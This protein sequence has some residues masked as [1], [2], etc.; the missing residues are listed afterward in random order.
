M[1]EPSLHFFAPRPLKRVPGD[2]SYVNVHYIHMRWET[3]MDQ[4]VARI[5]DFGRPAWI[6]LMVLGFI[7]AWPIGL[8]VL[9]YMLWSGRMGCGRHGGLTRWQARMAEKF[10][11]RGGGWSGPQRAWSAGGSTGNRAFDEYREATLRRLEEES[12]EFRDFLERLRMAKDRS[13]F[14]QFMADR[15]GRDVDPGPDSAAPQQV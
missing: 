12:R 10:E 13:E 6:A 4:M 2:A 14:D 11:R 8:A 9:A 7:V 3:N 15:K 1:P 5:D